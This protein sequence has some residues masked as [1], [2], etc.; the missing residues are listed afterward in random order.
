MDAHPFHPLLPVGSVPKQERWERG[1]F[2]EEL[3]EFLSSSVNQAWLRHALHLHGAVVPAASHPAYNLLRETELLYDLRQVLC[4]HICGCAPPQ[5]LDIP[6]LHC[7]RHRQHPAADSGDSQDDQ[8]V[9][10]FRAS[11][12]AW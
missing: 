12:S 11:I 4:R 9:S 3:W 8:W 5:A 1:W 2:S 10:K 6:G 7:V